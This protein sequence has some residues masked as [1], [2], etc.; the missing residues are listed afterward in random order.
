MTTP[1]P[2]SWLLAVDFGTSNTAAAHI[3]LRSQRPETLPLTH[4]GNL[5]SSAVFVESPDSIDVGDV[6]LNRAE[7]NPAAFL[8]SPKRIIGQPLVLVGGY[9]IATWVPVA[10]VLRS[11]LDRATAAHRGQRPTAL[12]LTHPE[13]WSDRERSV[14]LDAAAHLGYPPQTVTL[15]S[16]PRA[17]AHFYTRTTGLQRGQKIAVFDFGG[18]TF[19]V[20]VLT[21]TGFG[22][23]EVIGARGDNT[24]GGKNIDALIRRWVDQQL[25][26]NDPGLLAFLRGGA[27]PHVLRTLDDSIQRAKELLSSTM[28]ATI[29]VTDSRSDQ[30]Q[31]F[32]LDRGTFEDI[33]APEIE[34]AIALTRGT[35][36][37]AGLAGPADLTAL[38]LTGGSSRIPLVAQRARELGPVATLDDPKTVV[39]HGALIAATTSQ[40]V[41][42]TSSYPHPSAPSGTS[43]D[44]AWGTGPA[45]AMTARAAAPTLDERPRSP[46]RRWLIGSAAAAVLLVA[47]GGGAWAISG[48][49]GGAHDTAAQGTS[50][51]ATARNIAPGT[52][53]DIA[54]VKDFTVH[55]FD[56]LGAQ[57]RTEYGPLL[58][59]EDKGFIVAND[60]TPAPPPRTITVDEWVGL[61]ITGDSANSRLR[62]S[63]V[64]ADG[65]TEIDGGVVVVDYRRIDGNWRFCELKDE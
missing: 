27:A 2:T 32:V 10:A 51:A 3:G 64:R 7:T 54:A 65:S 37:D 16:E 47:A 53:E 11:V 35:L 63:V 61:N 38:Y 56:L 48:S 45:T 25:A 59:D 23:F 28:S 26:E 34:R 17:A 33:I 22:T 40:N 19:D 58:C 41:A 49:G 18:G 14:L 21:A 31:S 55:Y 13:A 60:D 52:P 29:T 46:R 4:Q 30:R 9:E 42:P 24:L 43:A 57:K 8:T 20:A 12:T 1:I 36:H 62:V 39:V 6:A 50:T 44:D 15:L 5:M